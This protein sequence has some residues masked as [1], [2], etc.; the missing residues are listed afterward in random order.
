MKFFTLAIPVLALAVLSHGCSQTQAAQ[1]E[2]EASLLDQSEPWT[3][4]DMN[5][6]LDELGLDVYRFEANIPETGYV[7]I[8]WE[9]YQDGELVSRNDGTHMTVD[10]GLA[11]GRIV[12]KRENDTLRASLSI[13][14]NGTALSFREWTKLEGPRMTD[15][16]GAITDAAYPNPFFAIVENGDSEKSLNSDNMYRSELHDQALYLYMVRE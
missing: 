6:L 16:P 7:K 14:G 4:G 8:V 11:R 1:P 3:S 13:N 2:W 10:A 12:I 5:W 15:L 9:F